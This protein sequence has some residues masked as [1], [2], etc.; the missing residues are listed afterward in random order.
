VKVTAAAL[1]SPHPAPFGSLVVTVAAWVDEKSD[2]VASLT[3]ACT[4]PPLRG[5]ALRT[6]V[7]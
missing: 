2:P 1:H 5:S 7:P 4:L 6:S 3:D